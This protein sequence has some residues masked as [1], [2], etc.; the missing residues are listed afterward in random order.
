M[1]ETTATDN[2]EMEWHN[3]GHTVVLSLNKSQLD[4]VDVLCPSDNGGECESDDRS[5]SSADGLGC[6][7]QYF[8]RRFGVECNIGQCPP[9]E[10]M[11]ICWTLVGDKRDPDAAQ[12]WF[13]PVNDEVF[14]AWMSSHE[15]PDPE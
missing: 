11:E 6:I 9:E 14:Y 7:V 15:D 3:D 2:V 10:T 1:V 13:V 12:L 8:I 4:V 5:S